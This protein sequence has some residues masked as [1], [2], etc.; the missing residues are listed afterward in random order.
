MTTPPE[1]NLL[2][3]LHLELLAVL[4]TGILAL[5]SMGEMR[6]YLRK[7]LLILDLSKDCFII[8]G[9]YTHYL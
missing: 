8:T 3:H 5:A 2:R 6:L 7:L 4:V 1:T 9:R